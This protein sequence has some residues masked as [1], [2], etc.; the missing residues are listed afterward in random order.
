MDGGDPK[1]PDFRDGPLLPGALG[2]SRWQWLLLTV[3]VCVVVADGVL[4]RGL[5]FGSRVWTVFL[6][7]LILGGLAIGGFSFWRRERR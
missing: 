6:W 7:A 2:R 1:E 5:L 3:L 4:W